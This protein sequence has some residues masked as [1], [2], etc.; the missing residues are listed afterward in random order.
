MNQK[1]ISDYGIKIG[2]MPKGRLN[3]ITDVKGV[4]VGHCTIKSEKYNTGCTVIVPSEQ[5]V[6][7]NKLVSAAYVL[8]GYGKTC[9]TVQIEEL[10]TLET[11]VALTN[12]LNV[13]IVAD[14]IV[15]YTVKRCR[16]EGVFLCSVNPVVGDCNDASF[17]TITDRPVTK[18]HVFEAIENACEDFEE[19]NVGAGTGTGC[20]GFKGGI[21]SASRMVSIGGKEF[22]LGVL[23][24]SNYGSTADLTIDG[25][26]IDEEIVRQIHGTA[27]DKGSIMI[28]LA[29]DIP[30]T[31]RQLKRVVKRCSVGMARLGS[32]ID[33]GSGEVF[34]GFSTA[35]VI[36]E[37]DELMSINCISDNVIDRVFRAAGEAS[38]EAILNS[39]VCAS[40][41]RGLNGCMV[42]S[43]AEYLDRI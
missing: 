18:E 40:S 41:A 26:H 2:T 8:N 16:E 12:T 17:N 1:R 34:I 24:Q 43:L 38:E 39:M 7:T 13:G 36:A 29:T 35:N 25:R 4:K 22:T 3:K 19:G 10:G 31:A 14:A 30:L 23:V 9:G 5:N 15:E 32:Y 21:G 42:Y 11:P 6:F 33:H 37:G 20:Y 27:C 28:V